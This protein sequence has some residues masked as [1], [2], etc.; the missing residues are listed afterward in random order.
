M[1]LFC[2]KLSSNLE[3]LSHLGLELKTHTKK[4]K[5]AEELEEGY[6]STFTM[7][8]F[9]NGRESGEIKCLKRGNFFSPRSL[10]VEDEI[11]EPEK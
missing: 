2:A 6:I 10:K 7:V 9:V 3:E 8:V 4:K 11:F 1:L 5:N